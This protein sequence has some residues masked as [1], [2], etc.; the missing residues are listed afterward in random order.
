MSRAHPKSAT[1][2]ANEGRTSRSK[3]PYA[4]QIGRRIAQARSMGG[5]AKQSDLTGALNQ[6]LPTDTNGRAAWSDSRL[7][8]Y[9]AGFAIPH[10]ADLQL[11]AEL[12]GCSACWLTFGNG[13]IREQ[14]R[15][16]QA[17]RFQNLLLTVEHLRA[18]GEAVLP[19]VLQQA[20][21]SEK[22]LTALLE[23]GTGEVSDRIARQFER[24][25]GKPRG[26]MDEQHAE[27]D[28]LFAQL[29]AGLRQLFHLYSEATPAQR[30]VIERV[31]TA[32]V[33]N[34]GGGR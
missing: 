32:M 19:A 22:G 24:A 8:S 23:S 5:F 33:S 27:F 2:L 12:T 15:S 31:V 4:V 34:E 26:W 7:G 18:S 29:P 21:M 3:D 20:K 6:R 17:V 13:P 9:E 25:L 10:P 14:A 1:S 16:L 11:I 28:P 30:E